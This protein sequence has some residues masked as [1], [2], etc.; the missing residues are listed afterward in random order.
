V[1][2]DD[3]RRVAAVSAAAAR[4]RIDYTAAA[5]IRGLDAAGIPCILLKGASVAHW[6]YEPEDAREYGDCDL[7][8][9]P[10]EFATALQAL[11]K[12]GFA[13]E[14]DEAEMPSWWREH[15]LAT[16]RQ[17]DG[18]AIDVHR[19]LPGVQVTDAQLWAAL[20]VT[21]DAMP[22]GDSMANVLA[23]PGRALHAALHVAQHGGWA[24]DLDVLARAIDRMDDDGWRAAAELASTL[25][26]TAAFRLGLRLLPAGE[27]L[28]QRLGLARDSA[29]DVELRAAGSAEALTLARVFDADGV[30]P[31]LSLVRHKLVPPPT[32]M[33]KWSPLA[34]QG[35]L[36]LAAAYAWRPIWVA[37]RVPGA[38][39]AWARA[40]RA[41]RAHR[42]GPRF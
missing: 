34:R 23:K 1:E 8:V 30:G 19:S 16:I 4:L 6:L 33:R 21:T 37:S 42:S 5:A 40:R 31:R 29:I 2:P 20:S 32:F 39:W 27:D 17:T 18:I 41:T 15:A 7:L 28:A 10:G 9:P 3:P 38:A 36:G 13:P 26:A 25:R 12:L 24:R 14:L 35:R 22:V 11:T